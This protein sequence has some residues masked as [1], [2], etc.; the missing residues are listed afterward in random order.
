MLAATGAQV[1]P[2][3]AVHAGSEGYFRD[4]DVRPSLLDS[5]PF[6]PGFVVEVEDDGTARLRFG[7]GTNGMRPPV[8]ANL[9]AMV[10]SG[11][12]TVGNVGIGAIAHVVGAQPPDLRVRN[13]VPAVG[14]TDPEPL[15]NVRLHAPT[16]FRSTDRA[17]TA[18]QYSAAALEVDRGRGRDRDDRP[19]RNQARSR[20]CASTP[21]IGRRRSSRW[22]RRSTT[23]SIAFGRSASRSTSSARPRC[24]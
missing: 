14:G 18:D 13:P 11:G 12:G 15:A 19:D 17:V 2:A 3:V 20:S 23:H 24:P 8:G 10:R 7:D 5:G 16:A 9:E 1:Q 22:R 4:W 21:A 6:D